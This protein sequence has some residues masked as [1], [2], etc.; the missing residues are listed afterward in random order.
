VTDAGGYVTGK[1][2]TAM[3]VEDYLFDWER[4]GDVKSGRENLGQEM[5]VTVYR[6]LQYTLHDIFD[7]RLGKEES[8]ALFRRAGFMAGKA[9]AEN[10]M[11]L[12]TDFPSFVAEMQR[13]LEEYKIGILQ[14]EKI[15][16]ASLP[17]RLMSD[18]RGCSGLL[19]TGDRTGVYDEGFVAGIL[20]AY[21][22]RQV[23][24]GKHNI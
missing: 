15:D 12:R 8:D 9:F 16:L 7:D 1:E 4:L 6:L 13:K 24:I 21:T 11:N 5:P 14:A 20:Y 19:A 3:N 18:G 10:V 23:K 2:E 17:Q 22:G